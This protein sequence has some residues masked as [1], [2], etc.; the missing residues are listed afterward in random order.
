MRC[1]QTPG[2]WGGSRLF[3]AWGLV[4]AAFLMR[5][6]CHASGAV[7]QVNGVTVITVVVPTLPNPNDTSAAARAELAVI[8]QFEKDFPAMFQKK[9]QAR[10]QADPARYGNFKWD[11]VAVQL[12]P[13]SGLKVEGV[14]SDLMAIAG[15]NPP[16][17]L[18]VN[19]RK[20]DNYIRNGF[21][22]PLDKVGD[23]YYEA[24]SDTE[25]AERIHPRILP[26]IYRKGPSGE[27]HVWALPT[28]G[29]IGRVLAY[30]KDLFDEAGIPYPSNDWTWE[31]L[32]HAAKRLTDPTR[33]RSGLLLGADAGWEFTTF[34]WS[35]GAEVMEYDEA[36]DKW[37][38]VFGSREAAVALDF[39]TR[40]TM[41]PWKTVSGQT[42]RGYAISDRKLGGPKWERGDIGMN[43]IYIDQNFFSGLN[44]DLVGLAPVP[45]GPGGLRAA[46]LNSRML[47]LFSQIKTDAVRDAAWEYI[48]YQ[49]SEEAI[50]IRTRILVESGLG[51][52]V[53]PKNLVR[54]GYADVARL[55]PKGWNEVFQVAYESGR[56]EPYG[57]NSNLAYRMLGQPVNEVAQLALQNALPEDSGERIALLERIVKNAQAKANE[58]MIGEVSRENRTWRNYTA[59]VFLSSV[60]IAFCFLFF[61]IFQVF[62]EGTGPSDR[63][64]IPLR[65]SILVYLLLT[66]ALLSILIWKYYPLVVGSMMGFQDYRL[67]G[68]SE[69]VGLKNFGDVLW[70]DLWWRS[71]WNSLRFSFLALTFGFLPPLVLAVL[72]QEVPRGKITYRLIFYLPAVLAGLVTI[73]LWKQFYD[74]SP[75]GIL[76]IL[77]TK[78]PA[79]VFFL[80]AAAILGM[81]CL[82]A[83]RFFFHGQKLASAV[84]VLIGG[85]VAMSVASI[86][87]PVVAG[88]GIAG[89]FRMLPEPIQWLRDPRYAM[90][91]CIIPGI[92][93][94]MGPGCLV[95]LAALKSIPNDYYE[96]AEIDGAGFVDKIIAIVLPM[97]RPLI[98]ITFVGAFIGSWVNSSDVILALTAGQADTEVAPLS[99]FYKAF[100]YLEFGPATAMAWMLALFLIGFTVYQLKMLS[101]VEFR[102][103]A[104]K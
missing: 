5:D 98:V 61:K 49:D 29:F 47:G 82:L 93:A 73:L 48:F 90:I 65:R 83:R 6:A 17:V 37:K 64:K 71:I 51:R 12:L 18:F 68:H 62:G 86:A 38:C 11:K 84:A 57:R 24:L 76:N 75:N 31:D 7:R 59:L 80:L 77:I 9:Y 39:Y 94:G 23:Q 101:R 85:V 91:S 30:R 78:V 34:L 56:P 79:V 33:G 54:F 42:A 74:P 88:A 72:L 4:V 3:L 96:A 66:P 50:E 19:F 58:L 8:Q 26:V 95:Y 2:L 100:V 35:A 81:A 27:K 53:N 69:W 41:E 44:P 46:E 104:Q 22:Y 32:Y 28:G 97:M 55:A 67:L 21:L 13:F 1:L 16:D 92:W 36:A 43:L 99:I 102:G 10:Y 14:E 60:A 52:F 45:K 63:M 40:L 89:L 70:D 25:K 20:S 103:V 87:W 15:G